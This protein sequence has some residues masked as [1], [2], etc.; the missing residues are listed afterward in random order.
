V[1]GFGIQDVW[2]ASL[3]TNGY[4]HYAPKTASR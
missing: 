4:T 3:S 2:D 1:R